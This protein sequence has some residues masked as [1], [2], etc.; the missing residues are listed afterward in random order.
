[1]LKSSLRY[2]E[3]TLLTAAIGPASGGNSGWQRAVS[4][5]PVPA[6]HAGGRRFESRRSGCLQCAGAYRPCP[7]SQPSTVSATSRHPLSIVS[8][9]PRSA[10]VRRSVM[11]GDLR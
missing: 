2:T 9:W 1:M 7:P 6:C 5:V 11:A 8:E 4:V 3:T 10:N